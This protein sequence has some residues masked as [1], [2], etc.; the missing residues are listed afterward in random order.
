MNK[1][2]MNTCSTGHSGIRK[3][4]RRRSRNHAGAGTGTGTEVQ[5]AARF[6]SEV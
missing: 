3:Q 5:Q 1:C 4:I 6:Y 2:R